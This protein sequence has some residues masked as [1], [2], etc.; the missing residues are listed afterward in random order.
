[1]KAQNWLYPLNPKS[2]LGY[3]F[4]DVHGNEHKTSLAGFMDCYRGTTEPA[5]WG[6]HANAAEIKIGDWIWV[7]FAHPVSEIRAVGRITRNPVFNRAWGRYSVAIEWDWKLT[8]RLQLQPIPYGAHKQRV[9][10]S[11]SRPTPRTQR[12]LDTWLKKPHGTTKHNTTSVKF[13]EITIEQRQGQA[14]FRR[15]LLV[16]Y[17][18]KCAISGCSVRET[19]Q[20]AH[21][22][23]VSSNGNHSLRNGMILRADLHNLFDRGLIGIS[24]SFKVIVHRDLEATEYWKLR[25]KAVPQI[26]KHADARALARHR[27]NHLL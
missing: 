26:R 14:E 13:K 25:G 8:D 4:L 18:N 6:I 11:A 23:P 1:M 12:V 7:H 27:R 2:E 5:E 9:Q 17:D 21:I 19:L 22:V 16:M 20:A 24:A 10:F 3:V 15:Q